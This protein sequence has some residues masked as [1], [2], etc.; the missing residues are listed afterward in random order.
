MVSSANTRTP[1]D[2][3]PSMRTALVSLLLM[4][5]VT[6]C[7]N[8][9]PLPPKQSSAPVAP[10]YSG[11]LPSVKARDLLK[12]LRGRSFED[13]DSAYGGGVW[14]VG[15]FGVVPNPVSGKGPV[16][17]IER[18]GA[19]GAPISYGREDENRR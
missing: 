10:G 6:A 12:E 7:A 3:D 18:A 16:I 14:V 11:P 17:Y 8:P 2:V 4:S 13:T 15:A 9:D 19:V 5:V 1:A